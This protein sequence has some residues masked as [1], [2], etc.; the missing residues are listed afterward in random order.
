MKTQNKFTS[1][2][3]ILLTA[4]IIAVVG[5]TGMNVY[6]L[7][8][9]RDHNVE[10]SK[11]AK[12]LKI[13]EFTDRIRHHFIEPFLGMSTLDMDKVEKEFN[14]NQTFPSK[15]REMLNKAARDS[16]YTGVY[17]T[18]AHSEECQSDSPSLYRYNPGTSEFE[19]TSKQASVVCDGV[20]MANTRMRVLM[21]E[22]RYN[23]K[24]IFDTHR[25]MT[26]A[27]VNLNNREVF[28]YLTMPMN[29]TYLAEE[30]LAPELQESFGNPEET[31]VAVWVRDWTQ[32][33]II[34]K[35]HPDYEY[36]S[37][38]I[39]HKKKFSD[40]FDDWQVE[41]KFT[42]EA[43]LTAGNS[44]FVS[45]LV[46]LIGAFIL[47]SGALVFMFITAHRE[48]ALAQRQ[49]GFLANVT[50]ELK[51]PLAVIQAAG[52][53]LADGRV[54]DQSRLKS[55]GNHI[56]SEAVRLRSMIEKLLDVA[57]A[58]AGDAMVDP[59]IVPLNKL[60][61][62]YVQEHKTYI[63]NKG[64]T[65]ETAI[66]DDIPPTKID[67]ESFEA[68]ISNL[69]EN[70]IKYSPNEKY[71]LIALY[72]ANN[73]IVLRI[74]DRGRGISKKSLKHIFEKFYRA[75]D[76]LTAKTKGH[77]LGLSI[78]KNLVEI[79]GGSIDVESEEGKGSVFT[80]SFPVIEEKVP[81]KQ[82]EPE[83]SRSPEEN[84]QLT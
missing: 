21:E 78:V 35:S 27:L 32:D 57:K 47:L 59:Q 75:E 22:Y 29:K 82:S 8:T 80:V 18:P 7:Y 28:G 10:S 54:D 3:W 45:N 56:Y 42:S 46:V 9:I 70:A 19:T 50:H 6:S 52:E 72:E 15:A 73:E 16:I 40:F 58:D 65:L 48:Q 38:Y 36:D 14:T 79:N 62:D 44:S 26:L 23:N 51:T 37:Q 2:R 64:F 55:Y 81:Q 53:N 33:D 25:S 41:A 5:L 76:T 49:A 39:D 61:K 17:Y 66:E 68:I 12:Q 69:V 24:V 11:E 83:L 60:V 20:G 71:I 31:G 4:G 74:E 30:L 34:A 43:A 84:L 13:T 1:L 77:G 67:I 63:E